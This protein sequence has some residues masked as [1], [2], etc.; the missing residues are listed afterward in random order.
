MPKTRY[1]DFAL[2][3]RQILVAL[4]SALMLW[5]EFGLLDPVLARAPY[6]SM[7][8]AEG[9]A[10]SQIKQGKEANFNRRC[11]TPPLDPRNENDKRWQHGCRNISSGF[12]MKL[13]T[14]APWRDAV[15]FEGL[16]ITGA[17]VTGDVRL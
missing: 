14:L 12:V 10:W 1:T 9:W 4:F 15:P 6:D 5:L 17:R 13:L 8:M 2:L 11:G 16:R 3:P 7:T